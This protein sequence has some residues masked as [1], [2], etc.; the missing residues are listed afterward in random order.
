M[1]LALK[2][3]VVLTVTILLFLFGLSVTTINSDLGLFS[4][5]IGY[6]LIIGYNAIN[7]SKR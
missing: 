3:T 4:L 1:N 7:Y 2:D 5:L 6:F